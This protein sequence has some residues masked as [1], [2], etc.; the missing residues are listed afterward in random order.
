[1][2]R[3]GRALTG[4]GVALSL[5]LLTAASPAPEKIRLS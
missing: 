4:L 2:K 1:M 5:A 3:T